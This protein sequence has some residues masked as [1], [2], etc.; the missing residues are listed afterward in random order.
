MAPPLADR[1]SQTPRNAAQDS[2]VSTPWDRFASAH[3]RTRAQRAVYRAVGS[4]PESWWSAVEIAKHAGFD[5]AEVDQVLRS[6]A[7]AGILH[8]RTHPS[9]ARLY[10][11]YHE[12]RYLFDGTAPRAELVDPVCGMP[13]A[14]DS[15]HTGHDPTG[16]TVA[17]C[18][19]WCQ[20][21]H[22]ARLRRR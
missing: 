1:D 3:L 11:W 15:P 22:R 19:R 20:A 18:S 5:H 17:F 8:E 14:A 16:A 10:C 2:P 9:G 4:N 6:F 13:V 12:L 21:A 7:G